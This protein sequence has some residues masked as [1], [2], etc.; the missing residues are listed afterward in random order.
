MVVWL[1]GLHAAALAQEVH[2][3]RLGGTFID[4]FALSLSASSS[5]AVIH[6]ILV[7]N[8]AQASATQTNVPT[9]ASPVYTGPIQVSVTT[10]V[11]ARAFEPGRPS[12]PP[13]REAFI[14]ISPELTAFGSDLPLV[15]VHNFGQGALPF[16]STRQSAVIATFDANFGGSFLTEE[17][18]LVTRAGIVDGD[19]DEEAAQ[20]KP[21]IQASFWDDF[22]Q[23]T[24]HSLL[25][26]PADSDW[27]IW[28]INGFDP[29]MMHNALFHWFGRQMGRYS[30]RTRYVEVFFKTAGGPITSNDYRG[31]Y[32]VEEI[33]KRSLHR[34]NIAALGPEDT[35]APAVSGGYLMRIDR[36]AGNE[37]TFTVPTRSVTNAFF[38]GL[39]IRNTIGGQSVIVE[40]PNSLEWGTDP[41]R[42]PQRFYIANYFS[43]FLF[44]LTA[45][46][47]TDPVAGYAAYID[48]DSWIDHHLVNTICYNVDAFRLHAYLYKDRENKIELGPPWDCDRCMGTGGAGGATPQSDGRCFNPRQWR[49]PVSG[50]PGSDP[51]NGT[52]FFGLSN[53]GVD[54]WDRLFRDPDFWQRWIDRYQSLR[55][56]QIANDAVL[57]TV[58][59]FY[60]E[61]REA[62]SREQARWSATFT[63]PRSGNHNQ[64]GYS[65]NFGPPNPSFTRGGYFT[66]EV[67]FQKKWLMDRLDFMDTNFLARPVLS[68]RSGMVSNGTVVGISGATKPG[69]LILYTLDG[70]DPRLPGGAVSSAAWT[71]VGSNLTLTIS[72]NVGL[73]ARSYNPNHANLTN[74]I[75][76]P[77]MFEVGK[78]HLNSFWSGPAAATYYTAVPP[79]RIT[80]VMYH[81]D[82]GGAYDFIEV[83]NTSGAP[84]NLAR[85]RLRGDVQFDFPDLTLNPGQHFVIVASVTDFLVR[86]GS[87]IFY[88]GPYAGNLPDDEGR[89]ILLGPVGEP[90]LDF[91]YRD[92]W[93]PITDGFGFSL[94]IVNENAPVN[95]WSQAAQWRPSS[96]LHGTPGTTDSGAPAAPTIYMNE[97]LTDTEAPLGDAIE[98][99]NPSANAVNIGG[100]FLTDNPGTPKKYRI[101]DGTMIPANGYF[102]F[103]QS[104]SF[105]LGP[106]GF[107]FHPDGDAAYVF[108][109]NASGDLSGWAHGFAF[110]AQASD[111]TF[112][113]HVLS[114][115]EDRF[116]TQRA[117][118]LG[119]AN[120]GPLV[121]PVVISEINYHPPDRQVRRQ[122]V[123]NDV[124]EFIELQNI[125]TSPVRLNDPLNPAIAWQLRGAVS[126]SFP[127][128]AVIPPGGFVLAVGFNPADS[129]TLEGFRALNNVPPS[130]PVFGPWTG[131]LDNVRGSIELVRPELR[132]ADEPLQVVADQVAYESTS[133]W[134]VGVDG[135][136]ASITRIV[137][138][139]YG[140]DPANWRAGLRT[141]GAANPGGSTPI[142]VTQPADTAAPE[143]SSASFMAEATG[144][145][146][147]LYQWLFNG[148]SIYGAVQPVLT[149]TDL[150]LDQ[151]GTYSV[152]VFGPGGVIQS[153]GANLIVH[154]LARIHD[155]PLPVTLRGSAADVNY[156]F[157]TNNA[158][159]RVNASSTS[160][161]RYQWRFNGV[162]IPAANIATLVVSNVG[163]A[164]DG[165]YDVAIS[166][167]VSVAFSRTARLK[168][169]VNPAIRIPP[170]AHIEVVAGATFTVSATVS[171]NPLP[172]GFD[173]RQGSITRQSNVV[174][175]TSDFATLTA[176]V[177]LVTS[178]AWRLVVRNEAT[179]S[180]AVANYQFFVTTRADSDDDGIPDWWEDSFGF[181]P[182]NS[183]DRALDADGD[184]LSN[185]AEYI[186]GTNPTD[187][188]SYLRIEGPALDGETV[189]LQFFA[190]ADQTYAVEAAD[191]LGSSWSRIAEV[192]SVPTNRVVTVPDPLPRATQRVYRLVTPRLN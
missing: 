144:T 47:F 31:V 78:P 81:G 90:I 178:Q 80:E 3:S 158:T 33:P 164:N 125:S 36:I 156:G 174:F 163:L 191:A 107:D 141:P 26:L 29:G 42:A 104:D 24:S 126:L 117:P 95:S 120:A 108:S 55:A 54:W 20:I 65:F 58:D 112:G 139:A 82:G 162:P 187:A 147:L 172:F 86:Y 52:D 129:V 89:I 75:T 180:G 184:G 123:D 76:S 165:L 27:L 49:I 183:T 160:P 34:V 102:V 87:G 101:P 37:R 151:A 96:V 131:R 113:R 153:R 5:N 132:G 12:G 69:T 61:I 133:P 46:N 106:E 9:E 145:A 2:F 192:V 181:N 188:L 74:I 154:E 137:P 190:V 50:F 94:V 189:L 91:T 110:D 62:Q 7:T 4:P 100:W 57:G 161:L 136:G 179:H 157:T 105:G 73:F 92:E 103:R 19:S 170:P 98:L 175:S 77:T 14:Q 35:N 149:L 119:A 88:W 45:P 64:N 93:R 67:N 59:G 115:G 130:T 97:A 169:L 124:D 16:E 30:S 146:P 140:D 177:S 68:H 127:A 85:F 18:S 185:W 25:G 155:H 138:E 173:W 116:V 111:A 66:N 1:C 17:A 150:R 8:A 15:V 171:G 32:L 186:A 70:T 38:N 167:D 79:L 128:G 10:L 56:S 142:I 11:H 21:N 53:V 13:V 134:P 148:A 72:N 83:E 84:L 168:V 122:R 159:F 114:T 6:Y 60:E 176:P 40:D 99:Y 39:S 166:N 71:N 41:R 182:T 44:A 118:T 63:Y 22:N 48:V 43:N 143:G 109:A 135:T 121:G 152:V 51:D 28:S 23:K